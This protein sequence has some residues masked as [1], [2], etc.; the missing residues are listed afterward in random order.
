MPKQTKTF[1]PEER[2][3]YRQKQQEDINELVNKIDEGVKNVFE[4][5]RFKD[6]LKFCSSFT[7]YSAGNTLLIAMQNPQSTL[8]A[9]FKKWQELGRSVD[10]G[11]KG[12]G[13]LAPVQIKTNENIESEREVTDDLGLKQYNEDGTVKTETVSEPVK[14]LAFKKVY[15]F[16]VSQTS[17]KELPTLADELTGD[18]D[19][20]RK[21]AFISGVQKAVK[22]PVEFE[23]IS[24]GAKGYFDSA[25]QRI[26][27]KNGMSD[28]QTLK[29]LFHEAAHK[30]LHDKS[31]NSV[32]SNLSRDDREV[33]AEATAFIIANKYGIDTSEYSFPYIASWSQGKEL[34]QLK[35]YLN[36]IQT[37]AREICKSIDSELLKLKKRSLDTEELIADDELTNVQKTELFIER[38]EDRGFVFDEPTKDGLL[39]NA[40]AGGDIRD[41]VLEIESIDGSLSP[42]KALEEIISHYGDYEYSLDELKSLPENDKQKIADLYNANPYDEFGDDFDINKALQA[43]IYKSLS[44]QYFRKNILTE[45]ITDKFGIEIESA[46]TRKAMKESVNFGD[47]TMSD[48]DYEY[49]FKECFNSVTLKNPDNETM[50]FSSYTELKKELCD[51]DSKFVHRQREQREI[52]PEPDVP[53]NNI[54]ESDVPPVPDYSTIPDDYIPPEPPENTDYPQPNFYEPPDYPADY[55]GNVSETVETPSPE[56]SA[57]NSPEEKSVDT[58]SQT[59]SEPKQPAKKFSNIIGNTPYNQLGQK[60]DLKYFHAAPDVTDKIAVKL[61]ELCIKFSGLKRPA[62]TTFTVNKRD[63]EKYGDVVAKINAQNTVELKKKEFKPV[64][65][66]VIGNTPFTELE[67][68]KKFGFT[69]QTAGMLTKQLDESGIRYTGYK[70]SDKTIIAVSEKD[71]PELKSAYEKIKDFLVKRECRDFIAENINKAFESR[72]VKDFI[73]AMEDRFGIDNAA[74]VLGKTIAANADKYPPQTV[75]EIRRTKYSKNDGIKPL[76]NVQPTLIGALY[77]DVSVRKKELDKEK[78]PIKLQLNSY[79]KDKHLLPHNRKYLDKD[80]N[81]FPITRHENTSAN[82]YY[83]QGYGWLDNDALEKARKEYPNTADF[84]KLITKANVNYVDDD[85]RTG[86]A[87]IDYREYQAFT[88]ITYSKENAERY[89]LAKEK[90]RELTGRTENAET[91]TEYYA[92]SRISENRYNIVTMGT[93]GTPDIVKKS[94]TKE[95]AAAVLEDIYYTKDNEQI[96]CEII[97]HSDLQEMCNKHYLEQVKAAKEREGENYEERDV[98]FTDIKLS[99]LPNPNKDVSDNLSHF[100]QAYVKVGDKYKTAGVA[101]VGTYDECRKYTDN[102]KAAERMPVP[103]CSIYQLKSGE[104]NHNV[105]FAGTQE[106]KMLG[107]RPDFKR[108]EKVYELP[109]SN[110]PESKTLPEQLEKV[111][112]KWS[113]DRPRDFKGHS[114]SVS[115]VVVLDKKPFFVDSVGFKEIKNFLPE[116]AIESAQKKFLAEF[117]EKIKA[118]KSPDDLKALAETAKKLGIEC[119]VDLNKQLGQQ[120]IKAEKNVKKG[121]HKI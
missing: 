111:Y 87:D 8:V 77:N 39:K 78:E 38:K 73:K 105:R 90:L 6:Y 114:L 110:L 42:D 47:G 76:E 11:Q 29:T 24:S 7:N 17:G 97:S 4:S 83:V 58:D 64:N 109:V 22:I 98:S 99:I 82:E 103:V 66:N 54:S 41:I 93:D 53:E 71:V 116:Q 70:K 101:M 81:G 100:V 20:E 23:N 40:A 67:N 46:D 59:K 113:V 50:T 79:F 35:T 107:L 61:N 91:P 104:E 86:Q 32:T 95:Q 13:I 102:A 115:D 85:G 2:A 25:N 84:G 121:G 106:L 92:V 3:E 19:T 80:E 12:I 26:A 33:Q 43:E 119:E 94:L 68:G 36:E 15:V 55:Y 10:K 96:N 118:V 31:Q 9:S 62:G 14:R 34:N 88:D 89:S 108:Y 69:V 57:E 120:E 75:K 63:S 30:F 5:G 51:K 45:E 60:S 117:D 27:V 72:G 28:I 56:I 37:A 44:M 16:D 112:M 48:E 1:T 52:A 18:I 49:E 21:K 74:Y 65:P